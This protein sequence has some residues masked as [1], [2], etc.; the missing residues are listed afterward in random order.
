MPHLPTRVLL[1]GLIAA[2]AANAQNIWRV[3]DD[4]AGANDGSTW[5]D[6]FT[7]LQD[8]LGVAVPGDDIWVAAG[9]YTPSAHD[10]TV[11]FVMRSGVGMYGGF[12]GD[13]IAR[14]QR[15]WQANETILSGDVGRDDVVGS[16]SGWYLSWNRNTANSGHVLV[17]SGTDATA[18]LDGFSVEDGATGPTGTPAND[19]LM[20][21]SGV[22]IIAGSPTIRN[23]T[24][25]HNLA[26]FAHGGAIYC[27]D[28]SPSI[29]NCDILENYVHLGYG[30]GI[31]SHGDSNPIIED[32]TFR[33][34]QA[35][36]GSGD[37]MGAGVCLW[38]TPNNTVT[39]CTFDGNVARAFYQTGTDIPYGGGLAAFSSAIT[40]RDCTFTNNTAAL[41]AGL[42]AWRDATVINCQFFGNT[43]VPRIRDPYPEAGGFGAGVL[44]YGSGSR[45]MDVINCTI[46][47]NTGKKHVGADAEGTQHMNLLNT[48][49][50]GN[51][52]SSD[53]VNGFWRE[54]IGGSFDAEYSCIRYIFG[55]P[56][57]GEDPIDPDN[58][59]GCIDSDP[60]LVSQTDLHPTPDSPCIDAADNTA[61]PG[62]PAFDLDGLPRFVDDP[63]TPDTG[64]PGNGHAEIVDMGAFEFQVAN[65]CPADFN[66]DGDVNTLDV[67]AFLNAWTA[68]EADADFNNDGTVNTLD[69]LA[70]LNAWAAGC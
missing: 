10:E 21:G 62:L 56:E 42:L 31:F 47:F 16:G 60:R 53:E 38:N 34:N 50:W 26:A 63:D 33:Y 48:I 69:V 58:I 5:A 68:G 46:A 27:L 70:F 22:Y 64:I 14:D 2:G 49:V 37:C 20:Y 40:V 30:G 23:C 61:F 19:P 7:D 13:E 36:S 3:D 44:I 52:G 29:T 1:L 54:E 17:A 41:G 59:P 67:L 24:F 15:D 12:A 43:A 9:F 39:R 32:C 51:E 28:G 4:A 65:P 18:V 6:A 8:A 57:P 55:P 11:S 25:R 35:V 66:S 45:T